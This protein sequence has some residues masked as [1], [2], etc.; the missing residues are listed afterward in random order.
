MVPRAETVFTGV[1]QIG[2]VSGGNVAGG[3]GTVD[4]DD[5][6]ILAVILTFWQWVLIHV[7]CLRLPLL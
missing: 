6:A 1:M 3:T 2:S 4:C 5:T 7:L